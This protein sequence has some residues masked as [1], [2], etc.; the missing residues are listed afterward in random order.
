[1]SKIDY[2]HLAV[3]RNVEKALLDGSPLVHAQVP[4]NLAAHFVQ[5]CGKPD[6]AF[7]RAE[8]VTRIKVQVDRSTA[9]PMECRAVAARF[10]A[11]SGELTVWDGTQAPISVRG[12]LASILKLDEDKV[13]VIA[14]DVGGGFGQ[15][16]MM[17]HPDELLVP[18]AAMKLGR[19]V[20]YIEDRRENFIGSSEE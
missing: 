8:H 1:M 5:T 15:K 20:K 16:I 6:D 17:F 2:G 9:A 18:M 4:N 11:V 7:A 12:G 19:P 10:D 14:P 3:E 13:R